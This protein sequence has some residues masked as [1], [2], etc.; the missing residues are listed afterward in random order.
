MQHPWWNQQTANHLI[1][2]TALVLMVALLVL[3]VKVWTGHL[4]SMA[5]AKAV[6]EREQREREQA[7]AEARDAAL[8]VRRGGEA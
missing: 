6:F 4:Y 8:R 3:T 7:L 1:W 2:A 5:H